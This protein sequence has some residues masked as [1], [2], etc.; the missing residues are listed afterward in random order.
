MDRTTHT[1]FFKGLEIEKT[2]HF[3]VPT[4]IASGEIN[5]D[6]IVEVLRAEKLPH[7][8]L[9]LMQSLDGSQHEFN[10]VQV[11]ETV[12]RLLAD[13]YKVTIEVRPEQVTD[14]FVELCPDHPGFA[15]ILGVYLPNLKKMGRFT[16]LKIHSNFNSDNNGVFCMQADE[17]SKQSYFTSWREYDADVKIK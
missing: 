7:V 1:K 14:E 16:T 17:F 2:V 8:L 9:G 11:F 5:F 15:V 10:M 12:N 3:M 6:E 13:S 4:L